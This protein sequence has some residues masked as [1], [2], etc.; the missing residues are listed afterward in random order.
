M[1][2][3]SATKRDI[4][5]DLAE[6]VMGWTVHRA[7]ERGWGGRKDTLYVDVSE[8]VQ[9]ILGVPG[10]FNPAESIGDA[11]MVVEAMALR[12][13]MLTLMNWNY[14]G[15]RY[16]TAKF[17]DSGIDHSEWEA[18]GKTAPIAICMAAIKA[19]GLME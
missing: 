15:D 11:M 7:K 14:Y 8:H 1:K 18:E 6:R 10:G 12:G 17:R 9:K 19:L 5:V 16:Y 13:T 2:D 4:A 3:K